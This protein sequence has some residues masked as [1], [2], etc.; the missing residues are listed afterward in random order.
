MVFFSNV[1][2][3]KE[4]TVVLSIIEKA[5]IFHRLFYYRLSIGAKS[6]NGCPVYT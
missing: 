5:M 3:K 4:K 6:R 2:N 1:N